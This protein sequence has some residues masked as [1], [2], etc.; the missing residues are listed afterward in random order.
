MWWTRG[1]HYFTGAL[2]TIP[3]YES[4]ETFHFLI[5][6]DLLQRE[7]GVLGGNGP[8]TTPK[9]NLPCIEN[10]EGKGYGRY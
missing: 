8:N 4:R 1:H 9:G 10:K 3:F 6:G 5:P 7:C 2:R